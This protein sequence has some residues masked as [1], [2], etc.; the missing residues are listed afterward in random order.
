MQR[1]RGG[2]RDLLSAVL[3]HRWLQ[4]WA[5]TSQ[6]SSTRSESATWV[7]VAQALGGHLLLPSQ[8]TGQ[9]LNWNSALIRE[10][11]IPRVG[12]FCCATTLAPKFKKFLQSFLHWFKLKTGTILLRNTL[13]LC[14]L[15]GTDPTCLMNGVL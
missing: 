1:E 10:A 5:W 12:L 9:E 7:A 6:Q 11:G 8:C 3:L 13:C 14:R 4:W 15:R 2:N